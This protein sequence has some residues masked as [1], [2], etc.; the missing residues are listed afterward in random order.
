MRTSHNSSYVS[1]YLW[2]VCVGQILNGSGKDMMNLIARQT[3]HMKTFWIFFKDLFHFNTFRLLSF[4]NGY[5]VLL[6]LP[7][8]KV[9]MRCWRPPCPGSHVQIDVEINQ[10]QSN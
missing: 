1:E 5:V 10:I 4:S 9:E 8:S 2:L 3:A 6:F 7:G